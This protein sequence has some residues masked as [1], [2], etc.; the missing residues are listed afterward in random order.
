MR[1]GRYIQGSIG[2]IRYLAC[3]AVL[4]VLALPAWAGESESSGDFY[5]GD[6]GQ[7]AV[8]I[9]ILL[10]LLAVLGKYAWKPLTAQLEKREK[11]IQ[12]TIDE[13]IKRETQAADLLAQY[14]ERLDAAQA[15]AAEVLAKGRQDAA[16]ARETVL[17]AAQDEV[18]QA[19]EAARQEIEQAKTKA[20]NELYDATAH[21]AAEVAGQVI[22]RNLTGDDRKRLLDDSLDEIRKKGLN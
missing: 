2:S 16:L 4:M 14:R 9:L 17:A 8:T 15:Q 22:R 7:A 20:L 12:K 13:A 3:V 21:L 11:S 10:L 18:R 19:G 5:F 1:I 6:V